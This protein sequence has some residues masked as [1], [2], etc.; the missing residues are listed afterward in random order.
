[1]TT[2]FLILKAH[3]QRVPGKNLR[4][5]AG[6]P[7]FRWIVDSLLQ[8]PEISGLLIDTDCAD[9]LV[10]AG[11]PA[12]PRLQ[13]VARDP[14]LRGDAVTADALIG[15]NLPRL[16]AG[17]ILMT[18]ATTP[19]LRPATLSRAIAAFEAGP[20]DSLLGVSVHQAR[21]WSG[22]GAPLNHDPA[23]LVP[24]QELPPW[25]EENS[26]IY[27]FR[28]AT[29]HEVGGRVGRRPLL[30]PTP[31]LESVDIDTEEDWA[32]AEAIARGLAPQGPYSP[33]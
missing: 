31:R 33:G 32:L 12:D 11:L 17:P 7:L 19:F 23:R 29:F 28:A 14:A 4:L 30:F 21:F 16:G 20:Q 10:Q 22:P 26:T 13:L 27:L 24:T 6:R 9:R 15:A 25:F 2:A 8:T 18:H 5:L 3:S 1:M